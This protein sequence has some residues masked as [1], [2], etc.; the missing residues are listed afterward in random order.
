MYFDIA[1]KALKITVRKPSKAT[2]T[3]WVAHRERALEVVQQDWP[4]LVEHLLQVKLADKQERGRKAAGLY[5]TLLTLNFVL[6][7]TVMLAV[8]RI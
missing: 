6:Y 8:F 7:M 5:D 1:G 3:R 2:G 4:A